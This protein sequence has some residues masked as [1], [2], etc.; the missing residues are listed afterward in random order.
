[1]PASYNGNASNATGS[2]VTISEPVDGDALTAA[3]E[4]IGTHLLADWAQ[5]LINYALNAA[6]FALGITVTNS[7]LNGKGVN[8]TGNGNGTG[9]QGTGGSSSGTGVAGIG[10]A[11][12]GWGVIGQGPGTGPGVIGTN[13]GT[14]PGGQFQAMGT[15]QGAVN[16]VPMATPSSPAA[17]DM[18]IDTSGNLNADGAAGVLTLAPATTPVTVG[19]GGG[20]PAYQNSWTFCST[21]GRKLRYWRDPIGVVH[22]DGGINGAGESAPLVFTLPAGFRPAALTG[23]D[24]LVYEQAM[25]IGGAADEAQVEVSIDSSGNVSCYG[26]GNHDFS[27]DGITFSTF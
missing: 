11:P 22:L 13:I 3:S 7:T 16:L 26:T 21:H 20:A 2:Q 10:G 9:V 6:A 14:G 15:G 25:Y 23:G 24:G 1:M 19:A 4:T 27:F 18:W 5:R 12:N 8:S 17:G